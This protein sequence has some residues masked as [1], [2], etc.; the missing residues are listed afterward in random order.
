MGLRGGS[1]H[2]GPYPSDT[3]LGAEV[4]P[5]HRFKM[6]RAEIRQE[7]QAVVAIGPRRVKLEFGIFNYFFLKFWIEE[8]LGEPVIDMVTLDDDDIPFEFSPYAGMSDLYDLYRSRDIGV[9]QIAPL[10]KAEGCQEVPVQHLRAA[11]AFL[12]QP[13]YWKT[14]VPNDDDR[15]FVEDL[16]ERHGLS[17]GFDPDT[18]TMFYSNLLSAALGLPPTHV[19]ITVPGLSRSA[20]GRRVV[21]SKNYGEAL[22]YASVRDLLKWPV[23]TLEALGFQK[24]L[25]KRGRDRV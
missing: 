6:I 10:W 4:H 24:W 14:T 22:K 8:F 20:F 18:S 7:R 2:S 1:V 25:K 23:W 19:D 21:K 13:G 16:L 9:G 3:P 15:L 12:Q 5:P 17:T 11:A